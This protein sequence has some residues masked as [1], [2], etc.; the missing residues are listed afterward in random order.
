MVLLSPLIVL[1]GRVAVSASAK[2]RRH[3][4]RDAIMRKGLWKRCRITDNH[5]IEMCSMNWQNEIETFIF[6]ANVLQMTERRLRW[7]LFVQVQVH[8]MHT[9]LCLPVW[10]ASCASTLRFYRLLFHIHLLFAF[11]YMNDVVAVDIW[12]ISC[13]VRFS[14]CIFFALS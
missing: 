10:L 5:T 4:M 2:R 11:V 6:T 12:L 8:A 14:V 3:G 13:F 1:A 9:S 7:P